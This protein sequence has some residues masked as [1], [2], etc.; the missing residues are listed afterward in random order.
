METDL[1]VLKQQ[2]ERN[3]HENMRF[4]SFLRDHDGNMIDGMVVD[5]EK[6]VSDQ[7]DCTSCGNCCRELK[8]RVRAKD[9]K[10]LSL[11]LGMPDTFVREDYLEMYDGEFFLKGPPCSFLNCSQCGVYD[12]RPEDC[13]KFPHLS[14]PGLLD[15]LDA[16]ME[17]Y[18]VC[19]IIYN[20]IERL[21]VELGFDR[22]RA[23]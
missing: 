22:A 9:L 1:E 18:A 16:V 6:D 19:P 15:R 20:V 14:R 21:K 3:F 12:G 23:S 10:R 11:E 4:R 17:N 2:D 7:I 13:R 8:P 5:I